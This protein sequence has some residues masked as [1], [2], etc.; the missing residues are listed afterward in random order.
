[1]EVSEENVQMILSMG[2][3]SEAEV[4]RALRMA[5][6]D[7]S[8]A[9]AI[10]TD[11]HPVSSFDVLEDTDMDMKETKTVQAPVYGPSLPPSYDEVVEA[12]TDVS[13]L[14]RSLNEGVALIRTT[15]VDFICFPGGDGALIIAFNYNR[16]S[17]TF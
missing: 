16:S 5:K 2:F 11:D 3:P 10:L 15:I 13:N 14:V 6:N 12:V 17:H 7:L 4:R 9:V 8:D 1:M